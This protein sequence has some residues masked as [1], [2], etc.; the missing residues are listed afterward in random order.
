[1]VC[2]TRVKHLDDI[3]AMLGVRLEP[4]LETRLAELA[5]QTGRTKSDLAREAIQ[6]YLDHRQSG[7]VP[8][9]QLVDHLMALG[10]RHSARPILD[11]RSDDDIL[12][13]DEMMNPELR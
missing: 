5:R 10:A 4:N 7:R 6:Q 3:A 13:Y 11:G 9:D 1:M 12:G 2:L 8:D